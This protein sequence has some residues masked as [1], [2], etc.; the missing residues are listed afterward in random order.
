MVKVGIE[1]N[2]EVSM[3][4]VRRFTIEQDKQ[5]HRIRT[6][7]QLGIKVTCFYILGLPEDT[8]ATCIRTIDYSKLINSYGA[9]FSVFTAYPGTPVYK[10]YEDNLSTQ[11]FEEFTGF[12]L[13]YKHKNISYEQSQKIMSY[14]YHEYYTNPKRLLKSIRGFISGN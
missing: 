6:L 12:N 13:T 2:D 5:L 11:R 7:E 10:E 9:Q 14:A 3:K 8:Q 1:S 4:D